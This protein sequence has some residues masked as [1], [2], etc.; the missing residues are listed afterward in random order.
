MGFEDYYNGHVLDFVWPIKWLEARAFINILR[1]QQLRKTILKSSH[2]I[3]I[4]I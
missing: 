3:F 4:S 1:W 2:L